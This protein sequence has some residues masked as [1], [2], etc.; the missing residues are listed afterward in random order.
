MNKL[1]YLSN[2]ILFSRKANSIQVIKMCNALSKHLDVSLYSYKLNSKLSLDDFYGIKSNFKTV[3]YFFNV[4]SFLKNLNPIIVL[5]KILSRKKSIVV[6]SRN[7]IGSF[8]GVLFKF[9]LIYE[10]HNIPRGKINTT[11]ESLILKSKFTKNIIFISD[12][13]REYYQ[14]SDLLIKD[15]NNSIVL[16]DAADYRSKPIKNKNKI[17]IGYVGHLYKGRGIELILKVAKKFPN[18]NFHLVGGEN[19]DIERIKKIA[20]K[21]I[22]VH[23]FKNPSEVGALRDKFGILLMPYKP[24]LSDPNSSVDTSR[25]MSPLKLFEYMSSANAI[26]STDLPVLREILNEQNSILVPYEHKAWEEKINILINDEKLRVKLGENAYYDFVFNYTW[27]IRA[28]KIVKL[29]K[30]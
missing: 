16:H 21:N 20:S 4:N 2:S 11:I 27:D 29:L 6:F 1:I 22:I 28:E 8:F 13:L 14:N 10:I 25:W 12:A 9:N 26:I 17:E 15:Q 23:G 7:R 5:I 18:L 24:G 19:K 3:E 30:N